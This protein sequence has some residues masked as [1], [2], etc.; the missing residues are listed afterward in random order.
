[1]TKLANADGPAP[2]S[3]S[4]ALS[5]RTLVAILAN[6]ST[7]GGDRTRKRIALAANVLGYDDYRI[8]NLF[9]IASASSRDVAVLG[10]SPQGWH[11]ARAEIL[12][13]L[14]DATGVL[15]GFG[16][17]AAKGDGKHHLRAQLR[18]L[19]TELRNAGHSQ[20]WQLGERP[21]HPSR[22]HQYV[23]DLHGRTSG[24]TFEQRVSKALRQVE[25]AE[26]DWR[27]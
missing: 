3:V 6:P 26:V 24:G 15:L 22:W 1:M 7:A 11:T 21:R 9:S 25:L 14:S 10:E 2:S 16:I 18:W 12:D 20:V 5:S 17:I 13:G 23:S 4:S 19:C 8:I 27:T